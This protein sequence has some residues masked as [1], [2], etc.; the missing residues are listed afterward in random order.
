[1][2]IGKFKAPTDGWL[3]MGEDSGRAHGCERLRA[4]DLATGAAYVADACRGNG[5]LAVQTGRV[6]LG[7][8]REAAFFL[9]FAGVID[10]DTRTESRSYV[11]DADV[12]I[13]R[14][15]DESR[16]YHLHGFSGGSSSRRS[17]SWMRSESGVLKGKL[18]GTIVLHTHFADAE[19]HAAE[20]L[21]IAED[22]FD[23]GCTPAPP[24][25]PIAW[26]SAGPAQYGAAP[27]FM[28]DVYDGPRAALDGAKSP[29]KYCGILP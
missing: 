26:A 20:L 11:L 10:T 14:P 22:G 1:M 18:S 28:R 5:R 9:F 25:Q 4:Y 29:G 13:G 21:A 24:P 6:P 2:P 8:L 19:V 7:A 27:D 17:F 23:A 12:A 16:R 3:V 15:R